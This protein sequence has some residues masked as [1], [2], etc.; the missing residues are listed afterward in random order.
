M[1][2]QAKP[3]LGA[4][5]YQLDAQKLDEIFPPAELPEG[6]TISHEE[7]ERILGITAKTGRYYGVIDSWRAKLKNKMGIHVE[8]QPGRGLKVLNPAELLDHTEGQ[9][10]TKGKQYARKLGAFRFVP[11][12]RLDAT[13]QARL[14]HCVVLAAKTREFV[15]GSVKELAIDLAPIK[16]LPR[17]IRKVS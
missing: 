2:E 13:G 15:L 5:P 17:P 9:A 10:R 7:L 16:S 6:K 3:F 1:S 11:R 14:D 12:E 8:W 4:V